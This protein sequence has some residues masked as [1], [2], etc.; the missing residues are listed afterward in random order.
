MHFVKN[1][2]REISFQVY[3]CVPFAGGGLGQF[4]IS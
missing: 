3:V 2:I 4:V 1:W